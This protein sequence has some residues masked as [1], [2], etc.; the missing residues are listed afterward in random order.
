MSG[1]PGDVLTINHED[2]PAAVLVRLSGEVDLDTTGALRDALD[3]IVNQRR[4]VILD[5]SAL[6]YIDS[7]G[8]HVLFRAHQELKRHGRQMLIAA[9]SS[10]LEHAFKIINIEKHIHCVRSVNEALGILTD[11]NDRR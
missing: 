4:N 1:L 10:T 7:A 9:P 2:L 6:R 8:F 11:L 3:P 5:C